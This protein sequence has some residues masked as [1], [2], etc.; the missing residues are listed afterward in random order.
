MRLQMVVERIDANLVFQLL[1]FSQQVG[2]DPDIVVERA[3]KE[4]LRRRTGGEVSESGNK[5]D[6]RGS[7]SA[8][9]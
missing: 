9:A 6:V 4:Y 8:E 1:I 3:I 5:D 7:P 2:E